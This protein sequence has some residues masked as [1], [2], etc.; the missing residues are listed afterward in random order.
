MKADYAGKTVWITG[1]S[2]G[3]GR[4]MALEAARR[5]AHLILTA[6][7]RAALEETA[8]AC[9]RE[10]ERAGSAAPRAVVIAADLADP[11]ARAAACA[12]AIA[13][14]RERGSGIDILALNAG[15]TQR[16]TFLETPP[17]AFEAV[18][19]IDFDAPVDMIRLILPAMLERRSGA[20][21]AVS[22]IAGLAGAPL[23][24]AYSAAKHALAGFMQCLRAELWG[25]GLRIVTVYPA[26]VRTP[27]ALAALGP[28]GEPTGEEDPHI[29]RGADP[30]KAAA[31]ILDAA[32]RGR[33][34]VKIA[35]DAKSRFGLFLSRRIPSLWASMSARHA[36]VG[37]RGWRTTAAAT[38]PEGR[39]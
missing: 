29:E 9:A 13:K 14:A 7:R 34:E 26:Y 19:A 28:G 23:R 24:P 27:I 33:M 4:A 15:L 18:M 22:S 2:S 21:V 31:R 1:A 30:A 25:S 11:A 32:R 37:E 36:D 20:I 5:G 38:G 35:F 16:A 10:A 39:K 12:T 6:R 3:I 8:D 17:E